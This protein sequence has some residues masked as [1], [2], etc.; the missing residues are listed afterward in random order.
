[1]VYEINQ[2]LWEKIKEMKRQNMFEVKLNQRVFRLKDIEIIESTI[3]D[4]L[5]DWSATEYKD[6][7]EE[8]KQV[9][10]EKAKDNQEK[11]KEQIRQMLKEKNKDWK[12]SYKD[13][14][15]KEAVA[16]VWEHLK[17]KLLTISFPEI[18]L[19]WKDNPSISHHDDG[20]ETHAVYYKV[21]EIDLGDQFD[22]KFWCEANFIWCNTCKKH[23]RKQI[24]L[25]N[26]Y[27]SDAVVRDL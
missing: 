13:P 7:P 18:D 26:D 3:V 4:E 6:I 17:S 22:D 14:I 2:D 12:P 19:T 5:I 27:E 21:K 16:D 10:D 23:I 1:M 24:V 11:I 25:F 20:K 15:H 8:K 9:S